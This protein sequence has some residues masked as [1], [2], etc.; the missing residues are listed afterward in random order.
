MLSLCN[1]ILLVKMIGHYDINFYYILIRLQWF[2]SSGV[3]PENMLRWPIFFTS[4][5][6]S[7]LTCSLFVIY[8]SEK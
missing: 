2:S 8:Y 1:N 5:I 3:V 6:A 7:L 4:T